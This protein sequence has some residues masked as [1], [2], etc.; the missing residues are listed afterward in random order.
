[1]PDVEKARLLA[2]F[3]ECQRLSYIASYALA[4]PRS[5]VLYGS[6]THRH[7][8]KMAADARVAYITA[9]SAVRAYR[10]YPAPPQGHR[11]SPLKT[12]PIKLAKVLIV[13]DEAIIAEHLSSTLSR[14][15]YEVA[16]I[17]ESSQEALTIISEMHPELIIMD[18]RI[19]GEMDGIATAEAIRD[20]FD[21]PV[22]YLTAHT[23][24][25][26]IDRAKMTGASGFLAKPFHHMTLAAS[27]ETAIHKHRA[28]RTRKDI[29]ELTRTSEATA[30]SLVRKSEERFQLVVEAAPNAMIMV[31]SDGLIALVNTQTEKLFG[32]ERHELLGQPMEILVPERFRSKHSGHRDAFL[33]APAARAMGAGRDLF[34]L[35]RDGKEVPVEI[36]LSPIST[37]D[38]EFVL[39]SIIDITERRKS[40][41]RFQL[42]VE[43]APNAIIMVG[44]DGLI[45]LV[46]TQTE[47]LFG[48]ERHELLGR[49]VEMLV[50]ERFRSIHDGRRSAF[51]ASATPTMGAC[52]DLFAL[53]RDGKEVPVEMSVN[54]ISTADGEFMLASIIDVTERRKS[55]ERFQLVVEA[56]PNAM[57]MVGSDG[58]IALVN[59][60]T[61]KLFG[62][63]R[64]ELLGQPMEM[65]VPERF[66]S[67]HSGHRDAF[68]VA[69]AARAM[70]AGRDLFAL[71][72][73]GKE[74]PVEIGLN[75][76]STAQGEFVLASIIDIT[77]RKKSEERFQLFKAMVDGVQNYGIFMLDKEGYVL[78][79]NEGAARMKGYSAEEI[80]GQ[81]FSRFYPADAIN[82]GHPAL[83]LRIA[84]AEGKFEEEGWRI[85]RDGSRF[86]ASVLITTLRDKD[87]NICGFSKLVRDITDRNLA[88]REREELIDGLESALAEKT[89]LLKEV[90]HRVKNN[91]ALVASL[92]GM[93][94]HAVEDERLTAV[95]Q[96]SQ[97]R[98]ASMALI[99]EYLYATERLDRVSFGKYVQQLADELCLSY[100]ISDLVAI[101]V[102]VEEIDLPVDRAIPCGLILN[103]LLSNALKYGFP[104]NRRG[105]IAVNFVRLETG[106]L[107]LSC[108]DDGVGIPESFD[109]RKSNSLGLKIIQL[110]AKQL[111]G[112]LMLDRSE[113]G[114]R[115][116]LKF[117]DART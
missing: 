78:S 94:A 87:G 47:K 101:T 114:T 79:W 42:V 61:E 11:T 25:Q 12:E 51:A 83:E 68:F 107:L 5:S 91:L 65:L 13:E 20:R 96:R 7:L 22:I 31:G 92:L 43:A 90:H 110:L 104:G 74:V 32:Y 71:R 66:R 2:A 63:E 60:Q 9:T 111:K 113:G 75:P 23:D 105:K 80:V 112:E 117:S 64:H 109:W 81:H 16:G 34:A 77:E 99:H 44:S 76:I 30:L 69:P 115:F 29:E 108:R 67:K 57:I 15:G 100:A 89:A 73:D 58:L 38:G 45:T 72:R 48:Y 18:I 40:E 85:R 86:W 84:R 98:V 116:A 54:P 49:P 97:Q 70:G 8:V 28:D 55:E 41:E 35:R 46:N 59:T 39:A 19:R 26:S 10:A 36:G 6:E 62:Y 14:L 24:Q 4:Y 95:L 88:S 27:I 37:A 3:T 33:A 102:E 21:I 82:S 106:E 53:R 56:A 52:P 1:M 17:A 93:Q 50:P 103:E